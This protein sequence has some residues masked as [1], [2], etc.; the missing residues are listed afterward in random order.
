MPGPGGVCLDPHCPCGPCVPLALLVPLPGSTVE[1]PKYEID[2]CG[3][4]QLL[5]ELYLTHIVDT[6]WVH[7]AEISLRELREE[8]GGELRIRFDRKIEETDG[9]ATGINRRTFTAEFGGIT[10]HLEFL[11]FSDEQQPYL[12]ADRCTAVYP[13]DLSYLRESSWGS[14][15]DSFV[16]VT[17]RCDFILDCHNT[18][19]DGSHLGGRLP[20]GDGRPGGEFVSWF[21]VVHSHGY[22]ED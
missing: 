5:T 7:G 22:G 2:T 10:R 11:P 3:R 15:A 12:D 4:R 20:S 13:I 19:V 18:P 16:Y 21:R 6:N 17:L 1:E 9:I 14:I 8:M